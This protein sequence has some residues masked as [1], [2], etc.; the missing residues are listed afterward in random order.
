MKLTRFAALAAGIV[1]A[2]AAHAQQGTLAKVN[3][4]AIPQARLDAFMKEVAAQGRPDTPAVRDLV[5]QELINREIVAQ[6]ALKK[7]L[8]KKP[9]VVMLLELQ[10]QS[11]LINAYLQDQLKAKPVS[12]QE[13]K[14]EYQRVKASTREYK[15]RHILLEK[16]DEAK[17]VIAQLKKGASFEKIAGEKSKD[18][19]SKA[20]GGALDWATPGQYVPAFGQA[21]TKLKKG[22]MTEAPVQTQFGWHVIRLEDERVATKF[23]TF[24]DARPQIEQ[25]LR[26]KAVS[27]M[28][29]DLRAS[30][31]I[32]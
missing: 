20:K 9:E 13:V 7:G 14:D 2:A 29:A 26:Q 3:G 25:E 32:E 22:Q 28:I 6:A 10:R 4:V 8:H 27:K 23:P 30:A 18:A 24:E 12:D 11:V 21:I 1:L 16:E 5:K 17:Q 15:V 31:K 19:G